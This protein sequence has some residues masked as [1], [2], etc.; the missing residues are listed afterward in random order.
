MTPESP[1][2]TLR[3]ACSYLRRGQSWVREHANEIGVIRDGGKLLFLESD[4]IA[5]TASHRVQ[6]PSSVVALPVRRDPRTGVPAHL[7]GRMNPLDGKPYLLSDER[8]AR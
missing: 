5:W 6:E 2:L 7:R 3:E 4:L 8:S 1:L